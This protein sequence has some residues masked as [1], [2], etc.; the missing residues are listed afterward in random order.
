MTQ[1]KRP[2][3][4]LVVVYDHQ[5]RV[6]LLQRNDD[7]NFWQSI[8]GTIELGETP[9]QTAYREV[10][11]EIGVELSPASMQIQDCHT[12]NQFKIRNRWLHRYPPG[13]TTNTEYVFSLCIDI[14]TPIILTEHSRYE[15]LDKHSA[16]ARAWSETNRLAID[17][18]VPEFA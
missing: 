15:W 12:V 13:V 16:I 3:S 7:A 2:E 5:S 1:L 6:L 17:K 8:T 14:S 4:S 10:K 11:E 18:F 9:L